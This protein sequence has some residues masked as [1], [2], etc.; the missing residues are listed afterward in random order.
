MRIQVKQLVHCLSDREDRR[1][2]HAGHDNKGSVQHYDVS[3]DCKTEDEALDEF[4][5]TIPIG[6]LE[7]FEIIVVD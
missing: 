5:N 4:H 3:E 7:D 2:R 6:C 1:E